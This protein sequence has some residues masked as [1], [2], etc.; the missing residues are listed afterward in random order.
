M[1]DGTKDSSLETLK[2]IDP[3]AGNAARDDWRATGDDREQLLRK[4]LCARRPMP[5]PVSRGLHR[6]RWPLAGLAVATSMAV[7][8]SAYTLFGPH[9]QPAQAVTP[10]ALTYRADGETAKE[11]LGRLAAAAR[12]DTSSVPAG[13]NLYFKRESWALWTQVDGLQARS[14]VVPEE[15]ESWKKPDG[16]Q[17]WKARTKRPQFQNAQ[18]EEVWAD[19]GSLGDD[20]E[21]TEG[22]SGPAA[23]SGPHG[24]PAPEDVRG[25]G[26]WL[27]AH[28]EKYAGSGELFDSVA[29]HHLSE[30][31]NGRQ[32]AALLDLL[33]TRRDVK[34]R[35]SVI[36]RAGR[37]GQ[38]FYVDS[39][40]GGLP[41]RH[42]LIF[43]AYTGKLLAYEEELTET[44]GALNV[45][46]PSVIMYLCYL[47]ARAE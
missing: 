37:T 41:A 10:P 11:V 20:P 9:A 30:L 25:M 13:S 2:A 19:S 16:S 27:L 3:A 43:D 45:K 23:K 1:K 7:A 5:P 31:W 33:T 17:K 46:I 38:A 6:W 12:K 26:G 28:Y 8:V 29:E 22:E 40:Y 35:G 47:D 14:A 39:D 36:D 4:V 21:L 34:Y 32:R 18:D 44:A 15:R 24:R 42:T